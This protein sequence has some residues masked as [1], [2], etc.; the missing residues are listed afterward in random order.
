M[1]HGFLV[2]KEKV[3]KCLTWWKEH[4]SKFPTIIL[5]AKQFLGVLGFQIKVKILQRCHLKITKIDVLVMTF[6]NWYENARTNCS[7]I[8]FLK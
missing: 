3:V 2:S 7:F 8:V 4:A 5:L 6:K 1:F